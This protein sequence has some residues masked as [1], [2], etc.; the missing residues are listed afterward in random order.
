MKSEKLL[1]PA[2]SSISSPNWSRMKPAPPA[3]R[4][5]SKKAPT[6]ASKASARFDSR[7]L[8]AGES[9]AP[10]QPQEPSQADLLARR[11]RTGA[12]TTRARV[13][14]RWP[15]WRPGKAL[16]KIVPDD[17]AEY[18][19]AEELQTFVALVSPSRWRTICASGPSSTGQGP[20]AGNRSSRRGPRLAGGRPPDW[21]RAHPYTSV[22]F[23]KARQAL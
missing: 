13:L 9:L 14:A 1:P 20:R 16:V 11:A 2:A 6:T 4:R 22:N 23:L 7:V 21:D 19:V 12:L 10:A 3:G 5:R 15:S 8:A 17:Q 18:R